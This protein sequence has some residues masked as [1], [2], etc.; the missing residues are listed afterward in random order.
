MIQNKINAS[1]NNNCLKL[2]LFK[3]ILYFIFFNHIVYISFLFITKK[4]LIKRSVFIFYYKIF[5]QKT[6][7]KFSL[8]NKHSVIVA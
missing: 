4:S 3:D 8:Q 1:E 5:S 7:N 6:V 2:Q